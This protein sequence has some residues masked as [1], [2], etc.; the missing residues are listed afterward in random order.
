MHTHTVSDLCATGD[1]D[2]E[3][4]CISSPGSYKCACKDGFTLMDDGRSCSGECVMCVHLRRYLSKSPRCAPT[5]TRPEVSDIIRACH[6]APRVTRSDVSDIS[7]LQ[8][9]GDRRGVPD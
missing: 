6:C 7:S 3:Q 8:Q 5:V 1:H 2:C 4:V 9:L